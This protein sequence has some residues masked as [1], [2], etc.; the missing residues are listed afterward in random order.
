[1]TKNPKT[2]PNIVFI[3]SFILFFPFNSKIVSSFFFQFLSLKFYNRKMNNILKSFHF[4]FHILNIQFSYFLYFILS[5]P[6]TL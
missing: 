3:S 2:N 1:M 6:L 5:L 4:Q